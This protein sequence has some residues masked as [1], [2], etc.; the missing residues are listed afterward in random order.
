MAQW[1]LFTEIHKRLVGRLGVGSPAPGVADSSHVGGK[2]FR[3][4]VA[5]GYVDPVEVMFWI[6]EVSRGIEFKRLII[7][8]STLLS[9]QV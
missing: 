9:C 3:L 4:S 6:R 8:E 1:E 2:A 7:C 5:M